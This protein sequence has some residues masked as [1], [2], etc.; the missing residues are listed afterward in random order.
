MC[1]WLML[2]VGGVVYAENSFPKIAAIFDFN[3][4]FSENSATG[5]RLQAFTDNRY[6]VKRNS[7]KWVKKTYQNTAAY[8]LG[9]GFGNYIVPSLRKQEGNTKNLYH[10][11]TA[12]S[13]CYQN[14][15]LV[16]P[17]IGIYPGV[18]WGIKKDYFVNP[19]AGINIST[20][21]GH[22]DWV[23]KS[24]ELSGQARIEYNTML[25]TAFIS[26]GIVLKII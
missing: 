21:R 24:Y 11:Y 1:L 23:G 3:I 7:Y 26:F 18:T 13:L 8:S 5:L 25:S 10:V 19:V 22:R 6:F 4:P 9:V 17:F 12:L 20:Y 14:E 16:E 2:G 15:N